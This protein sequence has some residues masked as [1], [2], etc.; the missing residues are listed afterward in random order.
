MFAKAQR[1]AVIKLVAEHSQI[2]GGSNCFQTSTPLP[3]PRI[4]SAK[5]VEVKVNGYV[6]TSCCE[7]DPLEVTLTHSGSGHKPQ[8][9]PPQLTRHNCTDFIVFIARLARQPRH[10]ATYRPVMPQP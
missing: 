7:V 6:G 1:R 3:S 4:R 8:T 5:V 9:E 2:A 10:C